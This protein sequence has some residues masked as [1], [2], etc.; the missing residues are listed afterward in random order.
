SGKASQEM[1]DDYASIVILT[2][3]NKELKTIN[4]K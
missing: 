2:R 4:A 1:P 3:K